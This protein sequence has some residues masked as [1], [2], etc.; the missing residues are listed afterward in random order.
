MPGSEILFTDEEVLRASNIINKK[1]EQNRHVL[2]VNAYEN[3][4][5]HKQ[6]IIDKIIEGNLDS[7]VYKYYSLL[8]D[9]HYSIFDYCKDFVKV[10]VGYNSIQNSN[11]IYVLII[12]MQLISDRKDS[13][14]NI[15]NYDYGVE[16]FYRPFDSL[17]ATKSIL[18]ID[19]PHRFAR[20]QKAYNTIA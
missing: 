18:I 8:T 14:L 1:L 2:N 4:E 9:Y 6:N 11:K 13:L 3:L 10:L 19:E 7:Q 20:D 5:F 16:G 15:D 17:A 12:N